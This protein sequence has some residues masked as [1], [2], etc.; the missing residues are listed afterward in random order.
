MIRIFKDGYEIDVVK[1]TLTITRD[2]KFLDNDFKIQA[3]SFP[4]MIIENESTRKALGSNIISS[5][6]RNIYYQVVVITPEGTFEGELQILSYLK[7]YRKCNLRFYSPIYNLRDKNISE[8]LPERISTV[9]GPIQP[10]YNYEEKRSTLIEEDFKFSWMQ[11]GANVLTMGFPNTLFNLPLIQY[12]D[13]FGTDLAEDDVWIQYS[14]N[15]NDVVYDEGVR[16]MQLNQAV[17]SGGL[18]FI[19]PTVNAPKVYLLTPL[20][21][22]LESIG[23]QMDGSFINN[24][25]VRRLLFDS[26]NN[27]LT[28]IKLE[29]Y[30]TDI[31]YYSQPYQPALSAQIK[32]IPVTLTTNR[33]YRMEIVAKK[34][35]NV[36]VTALVEGYH[37]SEIILA[38]SVT[39]NFIYDEVQ[40][41]TVEFVIPPVGV[42]TI[43]VNLVFF[44]MSLGSADA[45]DVSSI[46]VYEVSQQS[47]FVSHPIINLQRFVPDWSFIDY[48]NELKK[49]FNLKITPNEYEKKLYIDFFNTKF[50]EKGGVLIDSLFIE[51]PEALEFDSVLLSYDNDEDKN[52]YVS[53]NQ[54]LF[55]TNKPTLHTKEIQTKFKYLPTTNLGLTL[56]KEIEDKGGVGLLLYDHNNIFSSRPLASYNNRSLS[57]DNIF[58]TDYR[59]SFSNYLQTGIFTANGYL[60][61][62][63]IKDIAAEDFVIIDNKRYYVNTMSY[64]ETPNGL[65]ETKLELLLMIY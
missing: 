46:K 17:F 38:K 14:G 44:D 49:L 40:T 45:L 12:P 32:A 19:Q 30:V 29:E 5:A 43:D 16:Y 58:Q 27:N 61:N 55:G 22:A 1:E 52:M 53:K 7:N 54:T 20:K 18:K 10:L 4:F 37:D 24:S 15:I 64:K 47:G 62:K 34:V 3:N 63:Q 31:D 36:T 65:Y 51:E 48:I 13:Q 50:E 56:T 2:N 8:F 35:R 60:S 26:E 9:S 33:T 23:Y 59:L 6:N 41:Y 42:N 28:E 57:L 11:Y 21:L 39:D 25:F